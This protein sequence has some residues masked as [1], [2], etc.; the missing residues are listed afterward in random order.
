MSCLTLTKFH[1]STLINGDGYSMIAKLPSLV[2]AFVTVRGSAAPT[3]QTG[4]GMLRLQ[5]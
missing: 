4:W 2:M 3:C 1:I 5:A